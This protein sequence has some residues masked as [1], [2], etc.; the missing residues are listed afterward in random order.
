MV[1]FS[2]SMSNYRRLYH[3]ISYIIILSHEVDYNPMKKSIQIPFFT[4]VD[5]RIPGVPVR[6]RSGPPGHPPHL[7]IARNA[8]GLLHL[9]RC[10][11]IH[12]WKL[13]ILAMGLENP[14]TN[15]VKNCSL[16]LM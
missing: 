2:I 9:H 5:D 3:A 13:W 4:P 7:G 8:Q 6:F 16:K 12:M 10:L 1:G 14:A 15:L 11:W